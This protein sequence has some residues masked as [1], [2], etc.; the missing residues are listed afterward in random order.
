M[1][2]LILFPM[3]YHVTAWLPTLALLAACSSGPSQQEKQ[4]A[5]ADTP[6]TT[7]ETPDKKAVALP[8]PYATQSV[9]HRVNIKPWPAGK[10]PVAPAGF[11]VSEYAGGFDSPR[12]LY[13]LPNGDVLVAEASTVPTGALKH[14]LIMLKDDPSKSAKASSA[15]RITLLRDA[16]HD[17]H[18]EVRA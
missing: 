18:P 2:Y 10:T 1:A 17:G 6:A 13:V 16:D 4:Q 12:W 14:A 8:A 11:V 3:N 9:T 7:L 5:Q 15:N